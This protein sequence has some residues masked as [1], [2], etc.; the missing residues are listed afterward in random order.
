MIGS[1]TGLNPI[2]ILVSLLIGAKL[3]GILGL[4]IAV[5]LASVIKTLWDN[6]K[7]ES[8]RENPSRRKS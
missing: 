8:S 5:P 2:I 3:A 6:P 7:A 1:F 4:V